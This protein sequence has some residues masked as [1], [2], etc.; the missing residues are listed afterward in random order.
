[1]G[2]MERNSTSRES[3]SLKIVGSLNSNRQSF[4]E[5]VEQTLLHPTLSWGTSNL[6]RDD[7]SQQ[8]RVAL[9]DDR[10]LDAHP[11]VGQHLWIHCGHFTRTV[12]LLMGTVPVVLRQGVVGWSPT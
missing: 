10:A 2:L 12:S 1:M 8:I 3:I 4:L 7:P 11:R 6:R 5:G 9:E